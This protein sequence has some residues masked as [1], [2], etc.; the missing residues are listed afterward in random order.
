MATVTITNFMP[1]WTF[2]ADIQGEDS[3][4]PALITTRTATT[5]R[6]TVAN[7][8]DFAGWK[9]IVN[10]SGFTYLANDTDGVL[11]PTGG[12]INTISIRDAANNVVMT[13][14]SFP[15]GE[16]PELV[17]LYYALFD[18]GSGNNQGLFDFFTQILAYDDV[19]NGSNGND[20]IAS[21]RNWGNDTVFGNGGDD[22]I[23]GDAGN[24]ILD[25]GSGYDTLSYAQTFYDATSFRGI[26]LNLNTGTVTDS[27]GGTDTISNFEEFQGSR[28]S[29][30]MIGSNTDREQFM[31]LRGAD[32]IDGGGGT[33]DWARYDRDADYGGLRGI[34][35]N[36][37]NGTGIGGNIQGTIRDGFGQTDTVRNIERV[38]GTQFNDVFL[39]SNENNMF[40]GMGGKDS[41]DGLG[42]FDNLN[43]GANDWNGGENGI[44]VNLLK[45]TGHVI[46][47]GFGNL[48]NAFNME[49]VIGTQFNDIIRGD[50]NNNYI[51]G[52]GG[53]DT[54]QGRGGVDEFWWWNSDHFGDTILDFV[55]GEDII[56][57]DA[58]AQIAG[59]TGASFNFNTGTSAT[60]GTGASFYYD[61]ATRT[62][63]YDQDGTDAAFGGVA[64]VTIQAGGSI[65]ATDISIW[66]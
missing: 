12:L 21:G 51:E 1:A 65:A 22:Y 54:L 29:D 57:F 7:T 48:E 45:A 63:F 41:F 4:D 19:I 30:V 58:N 26:N 28:F 39:G 49:G 56:G 11:E 46:D 36:L 15:P 18:N 52:Q 50:N 61:A 2:W 24:D 33:R 37:D 55:S 6:F 60:V 27:W 14:G 38:I 25:G 66:I 53:A 10:G 20:D 23:K 44:I 62:L 5:F 40:A 43:F 32:L 47:D 13:I 64:V 8:G 35:A 59:I 31:G 9:V 3:G 42:G 34:R 16:K 17:E